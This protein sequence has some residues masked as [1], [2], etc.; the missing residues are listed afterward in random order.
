M[1]T[2][3]PAVRVVVTCAGLKASSAPPTLQLRTHAGT[4]PEA[5]ADGWL[6]AIRT[7]S[8][9]AW[10]ASE[11]Y[12]GAYW[13]SAYRLA[14]LRP[15]NELWIASAGY[16]LVSTKARI[17]PYEATFTRGHD[18]SVFRPSDGPDALS[19]VKAWWRL[20]TRST[21]GKGGNARRSIAGLARADP[22]SPLV[23]VASEPY[24]LALADDLARAANELADPDLLVLVSA[25]TQIP[26]ELEGN[27]ARTSARLQSI[28]GGPRQ[29]LNP[30]V[31]RM[32]LEQR[33]PRLRASTAK[34]ALARLV[35]QQ[36]ALAVYDRE[37]QNDEEILLRIKERLDV[38]ATV[39]RTK[40]LREFR[41]AGHA[42]EQGRF[43]RLFDAA[44]V[45]AT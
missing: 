44:R 19:W 36:P 41:D 26:K 32:L 45:E 5:R 40:L 13:S 7:E 23:V 39:S 6:R 17:K 1:P 2:T 4:T 25:A 35:E 43:A 11:L 8:V 30:R 14:S 18:D 37:K 29:A 22:A 33:G 12:I 10:P 16:G 28:V 24:V 21:S 31:A 9:A 42:C 20:L 34:R 15:V 27:L 3:A 38:D